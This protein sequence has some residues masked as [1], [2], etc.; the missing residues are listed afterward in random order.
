SAH[1]RGV[2]ATAQTIAVNSDFS[3][4]KVTTT[5]NQD[6]FTPEGRGW[7][8]LAP[9]SFPAGNVYLIFMPTG[10]VPQPLPEDMAVVGAAYSLR[11]SGRLTNFRHPA[12][13]SPFRYRAD[14]GPCVD[15][16][17]IQIGAWTGE[18][19]TLHPGQVDEDHNAITTT[20]TRL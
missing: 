2:D 9:D 16:A 13:L 20:I 5:T 10:A 7:L 14:V 18:E 11:A 15:P 3:M 6:L 12:L 4:L 8:H 17:S 1:V 19:W